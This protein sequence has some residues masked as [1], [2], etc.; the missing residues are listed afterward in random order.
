MTP[1]VFRKYDKNINP[2]EIKD[3]SPSSAIQVE[4]S[5]NQ[6]ELTSKGS[7]KAGSSIPS[8]LAR[9][10]L[11]ETAFQILGAEGAPLDGASIYHQLV[12]DALDVLQLMFTSRAND[13]GDGGKIRFREWKVN[14][15][16]EWLQSKGELHPHNLLAKSLSQI[17]HDE[18][19]EAF[20]TTQSIFLIYYENKLLGGTSPLTVFFTT[21]NW[22]RFITD[23]QLAAHPLTSD[24]RQLFAEPRSLARRDSGFVKYVYEL[25]RS[26]GDFF[27]RALPMKAYLMKVFK[28]PAYSSWGHEY[29]TRIQ[30]GETD[31]LNGNY[32]KIS[33][34]ND[35]RFL[36]VGPL[37]LYRQDENVE[38]ERI[39]ERSDFVIRATKEKYQYE[40]NEKNEVMEVA[41][42]L[43][44]V[45][46]MNIP[47]DYIQAGVPWNSDTVIKPFL[48]GD[49]TV[50]LYQRSLPLK[51]GTAVQYP[52]VTVEDFLEESLIQMPFVIDSARFFSG[53]AG[54]FSY[55]LPVKKK[56]FNFFTAADLRKNLSISLT[57]EYV[58]V[59]L[60]VPIKNKKGVREIEFRKSYK[61]IRRVAGVIDYGNTLDLRAGVGIYPFYQV[62]PDT[63]NRPEWSPLKDFTVLLAS[64]TS[65]KEN[66][67][68]E[69][70]FYSY[71]SFVND[72]PNVN[73]SAYKRSVWDMQKQNTNSTFYKIK[74]DTYDYIE[75]TCELDNLKPKVSGLIIPQF[76]GDQILSARSLTEEFTFAIDF[77]TSNTHIAYKVGNQ[78]L[79]SSFA[80]DDTDQQMVLLCE[81]V[82]A[83]DLGEK[84]SARSYG[85]FA[86][87]AQTVQREF[88]P[89]VITPKARTDIAF[90]IKTASCETV[91]VIGHEKD[92]DVFTHL[93]VAYYIDKDK[94]LPGDHKYVTNLK[95][96]IENDSDESEA[97]NTRVSL[98]LK[99]LLS[100]IKTKTVLGH[101]NLTKLKVA[102]SR[103]L[104]M[105]KNH[106]ERLTKLMSQAFKEV[107]G[108][109]EDFE[110]AKLLSPVPE[111]VA[112]YYF[113]VR[114]AVIKQNANVVNIDIGGGT[115]DLMMFIESPNEGREDDKYLTSSFRFAGNDIW[116]SGFEGKLKDNGFLKNYSIY[117]DKNNIRDIDEVHYFE[118][119]FNDPGLRADDVISLLF[120]YD[121]KLK[122]TNSILLQK[123]ALA[124]ALYIHYSAIIYHI[125]E[126]VEVRKYPLIR[127]L[128]FTG[129][130]S[131]Y[132]RLMF[133]GNEAELESYT[134]LLM[135]VFTGKAV[136]PEFSVHLNANPKEITANGTVEFVLAPDAERKVFSGDFKTVHAG[137]S[138]ESESIP[139]ADADGK[140]RLDDIKA[141]N[142]PLN[143]AVLNNLNRFIE[144]ALGDKRIVDFFREHG[145]TNLPEVAAR[146]KWNG[147]IN[148]GS[149]LIYE[150][151][152]KVLR[153]LANHR[154][155]DELAESLFFF[156]L[157]DAL[158]QLSKEIM[159]PKTA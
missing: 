91:G 20:R 84:F 44:L 61:R 10:E 45:S 4:V 34:D 115:T 79:P 145:I 40:R 52:F 33:V 46:K 55:L 62:D 123:P 39:T 102:W 30:Q 131:Q 50:P 89:P 85:R 74:G 57:D 126:L 19:N 107:F 154:G 56:Y 25:F 119:T 120:R 111:S 71:R 13:I 144:K 3:W 143:V 122:F 68:A 69:L 139:P 63:E 104:S 16:I 86:E 78:A 158:Y 95:W 106:M 2:N 125:M 51:D 82:K 155:T 128:S 42:P 66:Q 94:G 100:Q 59:V 130:G 18:L 157:K 93:N 21:P 96:L 11:F 72:K 8:P 108:T 136:D 53:F 23:K 90:P 35:N 105:S 98:F 9:L 14:E 43:V 37:F 77:G 38:R 103:P 149:G 133:G 65:A 140:Y 48:H 150:S 99:Q 64:H 31:I 81:P 159:N 124:I 7:S 116:G 80:V 121:S 1:Y 141:I 153:S 67:N 92:E 110:T 101:G 117:K 114:S 6:D 47:G 142:R 54:D 138:P 5:G 15:N 151:Y 24:G 129:K 109:G 146:L 41:P 60:K 87:M 118:K 113:L 17:F 28:L 27:D 76:S 83:G 135:K 58:N 12:S 70:K 127:T 137:Y 148:N 32:S 73:F 152:R 26:N 112:P 29:D 75:M 22:K 134:E 147:D 156:G 132:I 88:L 36:T 49:G 97:N